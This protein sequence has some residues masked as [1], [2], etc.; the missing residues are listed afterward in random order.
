MGFERLDATRG[1][2]VKQKAYPG[3]VPG[4]AAGCDAKPRTARRFWGRCPPG[5][6]GHPGETIVGRIL[7]RLQ[8]THSRTVSAS[9]GARRGRGLGAAE[10]DAGREGR[11]AAEGHAEGLV[12]DGQ[13]DPDRR[14]IGREREGESGSGPADRGEAAV[15]H[16]RAG[17][18]ARLSRGVFVA[19]AFVLPLRADVL[20]VRGGQRIDELLTVQ[21]AHD[22]PEARAVL[23]RIARGRVRDR[24][25]DDDRAPAPGAERD[26]R[27]VLVVHAHEQAMAEDVVIARQ[28]AARRADAA[29]AR[30]EAVADVAVAARRVVGERRRLAAGDGV[31]RVDGAWIAVVAED[32]RVDAAARG[33]AAVVRADVV[34]VAEERR[35]GDADAGLARLDAVADVVVAARR[36]VAERQ[37]LARRERV[38]GV[39]RARV[40]VV[41]IDRQAALAAAGDARLALRAGVRVVAARSVG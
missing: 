38:A 9:R 5:S 34:V 13:G 16:D 24:A 39:G 41:A 26:H 31:A 40:V 6:P 20:P 30:L 19:V 35:A 7:A 2:A 1:I 27:R 12:A 29:L 22:E 18:R 17:D 4:L 3:A 23:H 15:V 21:S 28:R 14:R 11:L 33:I 25:R 32:G 8:G 37:M 10:P 36:A